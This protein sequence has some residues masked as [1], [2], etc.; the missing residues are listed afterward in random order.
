MKCALELT[1]LSVMNQ[2]TKGENIKRNTER[3]CEEVIASELEKTAASGTKP[4]CYVWLTEIN[5]DGIVYPV[6]ER[7]E[8]RYA[9]NRK[10]AIIDLE[11]PMSLAYMKEYLAKFYYKMS[12]W[13]S[14][15]CYE[16][17][18]GCREGKEWKVTVD[19]LSLIR[20]RCFKWK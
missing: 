6:R 8:S 17:G 10:E 2:Q 3:W 19:Q 4:I 9:D 7:A 14:K 18:C 1:G 12:T 16:Y 20:R 5:S 15:D 13:F 11:T